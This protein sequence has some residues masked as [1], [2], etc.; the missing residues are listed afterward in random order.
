MKVDSK[1]L[2][3]VGCVLLVVCVVVYLNKSY[4][5]VV[6]ENF[7]NN[8]L[9]E[10]QAKLL[11]KYE[12]DL[13]DKSTEELKK[14]AATQRLRLDKY[15]LYPFG[16]GSPDLSKYAMKTDL[17]P[18]DYKKC[19]VAVAEDR[20]KYMHKSDLPDPSPKVDLSKYVLKSSIPPEKVCPPQKEIDYSKYV[21]KS[22]LPPNQKC[23]PCIFPKVK[24]SA[25]LCK[26][27]PPPPKCP[28]PQPCPQTKCPEPAPCPDLGDCPAPK[29]CPEPKEQIRYDIKYIKVP[30]VI[31]KTI[32]VDS[33]GNVLS[34]TVSKDTKDDR[35]ISSSSPSGI[36]SSSSSRSST[37]NSSATQSSDSTNNVIVE[38]EELANA[39][40]NGSQSGKNNFKCA[41][42]NLNSAFKEHGVY[43][44]TL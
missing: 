16:S 14:I 20:D 36:E 30:T 41:S 7:E 32:K 40:A 6:F 9:D 29:R 42:A 5:Q 34:E 39:L 24:V 19:T 4:S 1:M 26:K 12:S 33:N 23:P 8:E 31:T 18:E 27:C 3:I 15:G 2:T 21:L 38:E 35:Q 22:S 44:Y 25:G 13:T 43:G 28:P 17:M 10:I 11:A 37:I